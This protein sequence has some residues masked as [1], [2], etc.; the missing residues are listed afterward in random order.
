MKE[1]TDKVFRLQNPTLAM[2]SEMVFSFAS[3]IAS[4][5]KLPPNA[6][7]KF[8]IAASVTSSF[9]CDESIR[10]TNVANLWLYNIQDFVLGHKPNTGAKHVL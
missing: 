6:V 4:T 1:N 3:I 7:R 5:V 10:D 8:D 9:V 2:A